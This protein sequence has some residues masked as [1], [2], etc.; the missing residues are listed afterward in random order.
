M[1]QYLDKLKTDIEKKN[2]KSYWVFCDLDDFKKIKKTKMELIEKFKKNPKKYTDRNIANVRLT[3]NKSGLKDNDWVL[4]VKIHIY[5]IEDT[6]NIGQSQHNSWGL[7]L[8]YTAD[9]LTI[10]PFQYE[11]IEKLIDIVN[12]QLVL[13]SFDGI[14]YKEFIKRIKKLNKKK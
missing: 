5:K 2:I 10:K 8:N 6:G 4:S 12:E 3:I 9:D 1:E 7:I 14:Y 13:S 11:D